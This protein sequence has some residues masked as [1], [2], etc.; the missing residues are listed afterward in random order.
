[1]R[2]HWPLLTALNAFTLCVAVNGAE[3]QA[4]VQ[5]REYSTAFARS[6]GDDG[7]Q[8]TIGRIAHFDVASNGLIYVL[9]RADFDVKV[10]DLTGRFVRKFGGRGGGPGELGR[11]IA[12]HVADSIVVV[13]D[14]ANGSVEYSSNGRHLVTR[15]P[16]TLQR[17]GL[18]LRYGFRLLVDPPLG[19][20]AAILPGQDV[21][22]G[23][24]LYTVAI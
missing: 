21:P 6:V 10:Y 18:P 13:R 23:P 1:M 7:S 2:L 4:S 17:P 24:Y 8:Q 12:I 15:G 11:P 16:G 5:V 22:A 19:G 9:D 20:M 3:S 14:Q